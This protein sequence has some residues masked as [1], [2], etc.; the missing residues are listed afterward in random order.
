MQRHLER[1]LGPASLAKQPIFR[2][3]STAHGAY[4]SGLRA[5]E[6]HRG[7]WQAGCFC[8]AVALL[9]RPGTVL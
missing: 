3:F 1:L 8:W 2:I 5:A 6:E 9:I 4:D 7:L